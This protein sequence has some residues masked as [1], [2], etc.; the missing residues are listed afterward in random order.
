M[1]SVSGIKKYAM[2]P[3]EILWVLGTHIENTSSTSSWIGQGLTHATSG[4]NIAML[5][6]IGNTFEKRVG[7]A[8]IDQVVQISSQSKQTIRIPHL[9]PIQR[10]LNPR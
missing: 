1:P 7:L 2:A 4:C 8:R 3:K 5:Q 6:C 9:Y 10:N